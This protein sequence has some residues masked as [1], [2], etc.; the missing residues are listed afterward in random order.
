MNASNISGNIYISDLESVIDWTNLYPI[1]KN[2]SNQNTNDDFSELDLIL[3]MST[4]D[5]SLSNIF[6][7]DGNTPRASDSFFIHKS[8]V[9]NVPII[10]STNNSNFITGILWDGSDDSN[11]QYSS[12][13]KEDIVFVTKVNKV[14]AGLF[15]IYDYETRVPA[16]LRNYNSAD[17][18]NIYIYFDLY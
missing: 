16:H 6:T 7:I 12:L 14:K 5:D 11:G 3:S 15:G 4:V 13:D 8:L 10:N 17:S 1:G 18:N 2:K 9:N